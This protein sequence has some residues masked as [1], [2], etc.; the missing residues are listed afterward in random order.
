MVYNNVILFYGVC[1]DCQVITDLM[2]EDENCPAYDYIDLDCIEDLKTD[3]TKP[4]TITIQDKGLISKKVYI[5][6]YG[7][8]SDESIQYKKI[9]IGR[10]IIAYP[11]KNITCSECPMIDIHA[12]NLCK[13]CIGETING[14][15]DVH[16][17]LHSIFDISK[18]DFCGNC[19]NHNHGK[20]RCPICLYIEPSRMPW[21]KFEFKVREQ[22]LY[23]LG[24]IIPQDATFK[25]YAVL[26]DCLSC[27]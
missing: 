13:Q 25:V 4:I 12:Q 11:R 6:T 7:C 15:Y 1:V 18:D 21:N 22:A 26:D 3:P 5:Y 2:L 23:E 24:Y 16:S 20:L 19:R 8:C 27:S 17:M 9:I 10:K 14:H